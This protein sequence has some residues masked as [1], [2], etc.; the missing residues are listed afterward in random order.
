MYDYRPTRQNSLAK[1]TVLLLLLASVAAFAG[2]AFLLQYP[3]ILQSVGLILL[4]PMIQITARYL[5]LQYLYR[6]RTYDDGSVDFEVYSYRGGNR[7]QLV[8]RVGLEE[9]TAAV[10][11]NEANKKPRHGL[12]RYTYHPDMCPKEALV[13]SVRNGDGDCELLLCTDKHLTDVFCRAAQNYATPTEEKQTP[14][15]DASNVS[16][17]KDV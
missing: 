6:L 4:L 3:F 15:E 16:D 7:M 14:A 1:I 2:S 11:L 13:V 5:V 8:C 17:K 12:R 9:V 10:P